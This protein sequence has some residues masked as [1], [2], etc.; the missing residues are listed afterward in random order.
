MEACG[1]VGRAV[2]PGCRT[3]PGR[4]VADWGV[5]SRAPF[6]HRMLERLGATGWRRQAGML[7]KAGRFRLEAAGRNARIIREEAIRSEVWYQ[8][9]L[10]TFHMLELRRARRIKIHDWLSSIVQCFNNFHMQIR[11]NK[12][13]RCIQTRPRPVLHCF[14]Y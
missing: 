4:P 3:T 10:L 14:F 6:N 1:G 8:I 5:R 7:R 2:A 9:L 13:P 11:C 12:H